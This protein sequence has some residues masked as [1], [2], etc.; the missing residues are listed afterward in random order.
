MCIRDRA[1]SVNKSQQIE[2]EVRRDGPPI[3]DVNLALKVAAANGLF[4][5]TPGD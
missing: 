3:I 4:N 2:M 5:L 1:F